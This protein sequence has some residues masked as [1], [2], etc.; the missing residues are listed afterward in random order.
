MQ[1]RTQA[2]FTADVI[3]RWRFVPTLFQDGG[4][5]FSLPE[6]T[7]SAKFWLFNHNFQKNF[8][9]I[10]R[11]PRVLI[12]LKIWA[13]SENVFYPFRPKFHQSGRPSRSATSR[14]AQFSKLW[15]IL[16]NFH[17]IL[18][19]IFWDLLVFYNIWKFQENRPTLS[20]IFRPFSTQLQSLAKWRNMTTRH[21][22]FTNF[23]NYYLSS[24]VE[25]NHSEKK[26]KFFGPCSSSQDLVELWKWRIHWKKLPKTVLAKTTSY[27]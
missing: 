17:E 10:W 7:D 23:G 20:G 1:S 19:A 3:M 24:Q 21:L 27:T 8:S 18:L 4:P 25:L 16:N 9:R 15:A 14:W 6:E 26:P 11:Y 22:N 2:H 12:Y 13:K 5:I